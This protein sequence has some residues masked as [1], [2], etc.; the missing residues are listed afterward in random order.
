MWTVLWL[1]LVT[2]YN[3][4]STFVDLCSAD[5]LV[6]RGVNG[7]RTLGRTS[8]LN[9]NRKYVTDSH[10]ALIPTCRHSLKVRSG[11]RHSYSLSRTVSVS[12]LYHKRC[13][14]RMLQ[15]CREFDNNFDKL[16]RGYKIFRPRLT[17][18]CIPGGVV[19]INS[20][21]CCTSVR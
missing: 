8:W 5:I 9:T 21:Y 6:S 7:C 16:W 19:F 12:C 1:K 14:H 15:F 17:K 4:T 18:Y 10:R 20:K 2:K 3:N 13:L 11:W